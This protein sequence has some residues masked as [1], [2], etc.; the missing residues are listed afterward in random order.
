MLNKSGPEDKYTRTHIHTD[1]PALEYDRTV[2]R[3]DGV[4]VRTDADVF[5][6]CVAKTSLI[7]KNAALVSS[8][9]LPA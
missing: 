1:T 6:L 4:C 5:S 8:E 3:R 9:S 7:L 2:Y